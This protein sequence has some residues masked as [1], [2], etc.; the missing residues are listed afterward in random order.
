LR[1]L[2]FF[3]LFVDGEAEFIVVLGVLGL[4]FF[5]EIGTIALEGESKLPYYLFHIIASA[6]TL[7]TLL[8][9]Q[10]V[11]MFIMLYV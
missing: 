8:G 5:L 7:L 10:P 11:R 2:S 1:G 4:N 3:V 6:Q 9:E